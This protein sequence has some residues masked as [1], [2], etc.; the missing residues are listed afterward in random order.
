MEELGLK[1]DTISFNA[2]ISAWANS[3]D[4]SAG[5]RAELLLQKMFELYEAGHVD[6]KPNTTSFN[7]SIA[8]WTNCRS[9]FAATKRKPFSGACLNYLDKETTMCILIQLPIIQ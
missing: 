1:P 5:E 4:P 6:A 8:A 9:A 3:N 7:S 2:A